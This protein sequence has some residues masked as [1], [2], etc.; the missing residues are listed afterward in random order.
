MKQSI[1]IV[2]FLLVGLISLK[3]NSQIVGGRSNGEMTPKVAEAT[4]LTGGGFSG[5][6]N[7]MTGGF[8]ASVPLGSVSTPSGLSFSLSLDYN[9]SFAI[10]NTKPQISGLPYGDGWSPNIPTISFETDAFHK[11]LFQQECHSNNTPPN[12]NVEH[13]DYGDDSDGYQASDEGDLYYYSPQVNIPGVASGRAIFKYV[14]AADAGCLVFVLNKFESPIE[15]RFYGKSWRARTSDGTIYNFGKCMTSYR[16]PSNKRVIG[17]NL[18]G[19]V[20]ESDPVM[21]ILESG[22]YSGTGIQVKNSIEPKVSTSSWYCTDIRNML[23]YGNVITFEYETYGEFNYFAEFNQERYGY[24]NKN[25]FSAYTFPTPLD[26]KAC[27]DIL[28]TKI[29]SF[30]VDS[31][32]EVLDLEYQTDF[33][34]LSANNGINFN[35]N[36]PNVGRLDSLYSYEIVEEFGE[37]TNFTN[38]R[39]YKHRKLDNSA[40]INP[41]N[42]YQDG[43]GNYLKESISGNDLEFGHG[44]LESPRLMRNENMHAGDIYEVR[45]TISR[46]NQYSLSDGNGTIDIAIVSGKNQSSVSSPSNFDQL[47]NDGIFSQSNYLETRGV[48]IFSTF[49]MALKWQMGRGQSEM[50]TSNF[51]VMP[52][53]PTSFDGFNIQIG[54]GN[55][56]MDYSTSPGPGIGGLGNIGDTEIEVYDAYHYA[57]VGVPTSSSDIPANFGVGYPWSMMAPVYKEMQEAAWPPAPIDNEDLYHEWW[58]NPVMQTPNKPTKLGDETHLEKVQLIRYSKN[59]YMLSGVKKYRM[60]GSS[61]DSGTTF[62][63]VQPISQTKLNYSKKLVD[64]LENYNIG[65]PQPSS[66]YNRSIVLLNEIV[67]VPLSGDLYA[68]D[69]GMADT[70]KTLTT[71]IAYSSTGDLGIEDVSGA[72]PYAGHEHFLI[73]EFADHLGGITKVEYYDLDD[74]NYTRIREDYRNPQP[75]NGNVLSAPYKRNFSHTIHPAVKFLYKNDLEQNGNTQNTTFT[76]WEY[77]YEDTISATSALLLPQDHFRTSGFKRSINGFSTVRKYG[78]AINAQGHRNYTEYKFYGGNGFNQSID[79]YLLYGK[80]KSEKNFFTD[81]VNPD[82]LHDEKIT[83]YSHTLAFKNAYDRPN[84]QKRHT[85]YYGPKSS[86]E[87][88]DYYENYDYSQANSFFVFD[89]INNQEVI[90]SNPFTGGTATTHDIMAS[91]APVALSGNFTS[92]EMPKFLEFYFYD[93]L[94]GVNHEYLLNSYFIKKDSVISRVY[95]NSIGKSY[96]ISDS[97]GPLIQKIDN[98]HGSGF[99]NSKADDEEVDGLIISAIQENSSELCAYLLQESPLSNAVL[100]SLI[101][102]NSVRNTVKATVLVS[103]FG[104]SNSIMNLVFNKLGMF[105]PKQMESIIEVQ[106]YFS[107]ESLIH[108]IQNVESRTDP[109]IFEKAMLKNFYLTDGVIAEMSEEANVL[110]GESYSNIIEEQTQLSENVLNTIIQSVN[111]KSLSLSSTLKNQT[112]T[113]DHFSS[114]ISLEHYTNEEIVKLLE[115]TV[116]YPSD[117][118]L[119]EFFSR[120]PLYTIV[121]TRNGSRQEPTLKLDQARRVLEAA[122]RNISS[123]VYDQLYVIYGEGS[124]KVDRI[125]PEPTS[126]NALSIYCN[127]AA[128]E[129]RDFIENKTVYEYYEA[130]YRGKAIGQAYEIL[131]GFKTD[132]TEPSPFPVEV[133]A[134]EFVSLHMEDRF[135]NEI[136]LKHE[137]SWQVFSVETSSP[138]L[139]DAINREEYFYLYDL[140]NRYD[141]HWFNYDLSG[142]DEDIYF[143]IVPLTSGSHDTLYSNYNWHSYYQSTQGYQQPKHDGM[144]KTRKEGNR[145]LAFQKTT[146]NK[147]VFEDEPIINSEYYQYDGRWLFDDITTTYST[148]EDTISPPCPIEDSIVSVDFFT[149][150]GGFDDFLYKPHFNLDDILPSGYCVWFIPGYGIWAFP[151]GINMTV[152]FPDAV[153]YGCSYVPTDENDTNKLPE[154]ATTL[155]DRSLLLREVLVQVDTLDH[156]P[157]KEFENKKL[158]LKNTYI[159]EFYT[160]ALN[161]SD[162]LN[163]AG[164]HHMIIPFEALSVQKVIERNRYLQPELEE[165]QIGLQTKYWYNKSEKIHH[166]FPCPFDSYTETIC[167][168]IAL[169]YRVTVG[170]QRADSLSTL[171]D[172]NAASMVIKTTDPSSKTMEYVFDDFYRLDS[173]IENGD[174]VLSTFEYNNWSHDGSLSFLDRTNENYVQTILYNSD[175]LNDFEKRQAFVDPLGRN[176]SVLSIYHDGVSNNQIRSGSVEYDKWGRAKKSYKNSASISNNVQALNIATPL[177]AESIYENDPKG[178]VLRT[179][180]YGEDVNGIHAVK[181][182]YFIANDVFTACELEITQTELLQIMGVS[183][184]LNMK[185]MRTEVIDQDNKRS[186]SYT[187][188]FGQKIATLK[189]SNNVQKIVTLFV[190]D[191]AGNLTKVINPEKQQSIYEYNHLGQMYREV[192]VDAGEKKYMYNKQGLVSVSFDQQGANTYSEENVL[193]PMYRIYEYDDYGRLISVGIKDTPFNYAHSEIYSP[194]AYEDISV[195]DSSDPS[196]SIGSDWTINGHLF[197]YEFS[198]ASTQDWLSEFYV[199]S[200]ASYTDTVTQDYDKRLI[201]DVASIFEIDKHEKEFIYASNAVAVVNPVGKVIKTLSYDNDGMKVQRE[202]FVYD[203][204]DNM[205]E[206]TIAFNP[207]MDVDLNNVSNIT[208]KIFYPAYNYRKTLLEQKTDVDNDGNIDLHTFIEYD[209]LNRL[210]A[211]YAASTEVNSVA[212]A[213]KLVSYNH[214]DANGLVLKKTHY[215]SDDNNINRVVNEIEYAYDGRDR[216][217]QIEVGQTYL[218]QTLPS[219]GIESQMNYELFYDNDVPSYQDTDPNNQLVIETVNTTHNFNGNI[220]GTMMVFDFNDSYSLGGVSNFNKPTIYGYTYD[221]LNRLVKADATVGDYVLFNNAS[222]Y[223]SYRIGDASFSFDKIGNIKSLYRINKGLGNAGTSDYVDID[224]FNYNYGANSNILNSV[225]GL[226]GAQSRIYTYDENGNLLTDDFRNIE[227]T[228]YGRAAYAFHIAQTTDVSTQINSDYLYSVNDLRI[229]KH[230]IEKNEDN[231]ILDNKKEYYLMDAT[232][233]TIAIRTDLNGDVNWEYFISGAEREC[234]LSPLN[235]ESDNDFSRESVTFYV[236]DHLGNTRMNYSTF[237]FAVVLDPNHNPY[238]IAENKVKFVADYFPYGKMLRHFNGTEER[239]LT[240]QHE[241]DQETGLDYRGARYYDA[242]VARFLSLDPLAT[243]FPEFSAYNYVMGNPIALVDP[244]GKAP[245]PPKN[246]RY[247]NMVKQKDGTYKAQLNRVSSE[248]VVRGDAAFKSSDGN[249][250]YMSTGT[251]LQ[252]DAAAVGVYTYWNGDGTIKSQVVKSSSDFISNYT[253]HETDGQVL[254][255]KMNDGSSGV[256]LAIA[257]AATSGFETKLGLNLLS[258]KKFTQFAAPGLK[259]RNTFLPKSTTRKLI[260]GAKSFGYGM[261]AYGIFSTYNSYENGEISKARRNYNY[262][263][264][265]IGTLMPGFGL[266]IGIGDYAG[267]KLEP[268]LTQAMSSDFYCTF[269]K[270]VLGSDA[271]PGK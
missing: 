105:T 96:D 209:K 142:D 216:L 11:F 118:V 119:V 49:N 202:E 148:I 56:D 178:R 162:A 246:V 270:C 227:G 205:I 238:Y 249:T 10:G 110:P 17:Y 59:P 263:N 39:K 123:Q 103:Q 72:T 122:E 127:N 4:K 19:V 250:S 224:H 26:F 84:Y 235:N 51:F 200:S 219:L 117:N 138:Q 255:T 112:L 42:P 133:K 193:T 231:Q 251:Y 170:Y 172:Y 176:Q 247:Y 92:K 196:V 139:P 18:P 165:N 120:E 174:R 35:S 168:D 245:S 130:D 73:S 98:P 106:P 57:Q 194:L 161:Q 100:T 113:E 101:N 141:R 33:D 63:G 22:E 16:A 211:I 210:K 132:Y 218:N 90:I 185:F 109:N 143:N 45:T 160:G 71:F 79:E 217:T 241:R 199:W 82:V 85:V 268:S 64:K 260:V 60:N 30:V 259:G 145:S 220:N 1:S 144:D 233:K 6:V 243:K 77:Q 97:P 152:F 67:E 2:L 239:Y 136:Y 215:A 230:A 167:E 32:Y 50:E 269:W 207:D 24:V 46:E 93:E 192:T 179:S 125:R 166:S 36:N 236:Y 5:D 111:M 38:W 15:I 137:P 182:N 104:L 262:V 76:K 108:L 124:R 115:Q 195:H 150:L 121:P 86:Y 149:S 234:K 53:L 66:F 28:L 184:T 242:D 237:K 47:D 95:D 25:V 158:D 264:S 206:Q 191:N 20:S 187:N 21:P 183:P 151:V 8:N 265:G 75:C 248:L 204:N 266:A 88:E 214:D 34:I 201:N 213:R 14:D 240:T 197:E 83:H 52:N 256:I 147:N 198:N 9:S 107:D 186:V 126:Q 155:R 156:S 221:D 128:V 190:Y 232:G 12:P 74:N 91:I 135:I 40:S 129:G 257:G 180:N 31:P 258:R 61:G 94:K 87:Y 102:N 222:T 58:S 252:Q 229:F 177:Y 153:S 254:D 225:T 27:T 228:N 159:A 171:Y 188:A 261:S 23:N 181:T 267:Q 13:L 81:G 7:V 44:V 80:I 69:Y 43:N 164:P 3:A 175:D 189:Y 55:S 208:S 173:I 48:S 131:L 203:I 212:N 157:S 65:S 169:P 62:S 78:P 37:G 253:N 68:D 29:T 99:L 70:S 140:Q 226:S 116:S 244:D 54:P 134:S 89:T 163:F 146:F 114:I 41:S 154:I 271:S 223:D